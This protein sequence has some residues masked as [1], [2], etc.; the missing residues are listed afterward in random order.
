M[1]ELA[2][3]RG[4]NAERRTGKGLHRRGSDASGHYP[5]I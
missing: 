5:C 4:T 2:A 3:R 1:D